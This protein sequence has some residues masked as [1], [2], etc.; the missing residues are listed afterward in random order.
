MIMSKS[1]SIIDSRHLMYII[2]NTIL[3]ILVLIFNYNVLFL[4]Y[5]IDVITSIFKSLSLLYFS[6]I[7]FQ[8]T[9][10][11]L[12]PAVTTLLSMSVSS[13]S[14]LFNPSTPTPLP[15][16]QSFCSP[17]T[18]LSPFSLLVQFVHQIPH[19]SEITFTSILR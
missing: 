14:F 6:Y 12:P 8:S 10:K 4:R 9:Y 5:H 17:S 13:F 2:V 1:I 7:T 15:N 16:Q 19:M 11:P 3:F 18:G